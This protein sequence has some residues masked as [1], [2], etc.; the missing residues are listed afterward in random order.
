[1]PKF[2]NGWLNRFKGQYKI[3][4]YVQYREAGSAATDNLD[5]ITQ[6]EETRQLCTEYEL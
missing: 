4:E 1:M 6:M 3:K 5:N 2:S